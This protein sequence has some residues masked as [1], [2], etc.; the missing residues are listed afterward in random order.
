MFL[1]PKH[2]YKS[3]APSLSQNKF[4]LSNTPNEDHHQFEVQLK[5]LI[6]KFKN[7][8]NRDMSIIRGS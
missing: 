4:F 1:H 3:V 6:K 2:Y 8:K 5:V 7:K